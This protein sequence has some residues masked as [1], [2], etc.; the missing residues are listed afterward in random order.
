MRAAAC[1]QRRASSGVRA[2]VRAQVQREVL[3]VSGA[4]YLHQKCYKLS[5]ASRQ[6]IEVAVSSSA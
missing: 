5:T 2:G 3:G 4:A 6:T 1:E